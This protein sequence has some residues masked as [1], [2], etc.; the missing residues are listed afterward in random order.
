M[1]RQGELNDRGGSPWAVVLAGGGITVTV[2]CSPPVRRRAP[3]AVRPS[4]GA[5]NAPASDAGPSWVGRSSRADRSGGSREPWTISGGG[6]SERPAPHLLKQPT[7]RGTAAAILFAAQWIEARDPWA[8]VVFCPS[9]HFIPEEIEFM[10]RVTEVAR[11]V[12]RQRDWMVLLGAEPTEP[13]TEYRSDRARGI[14]GRGRGR[15]HLPH[16]AVPGEAFERSRG[17]IV[18]EGVSVEHVCLC[19]PGFRGARRGADACRAWPTGWP[20]SRRSGVPPMKH[21]RSARRTLSRRRPTSRGPFWRRAHSLL[22]S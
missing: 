16:P 18:H 17:T 3:Q 22:P 10:E 11:F 8:T 21:G 1:A 4:A 14:R 20:A 5:T 19:R 9:D 6:I 15:P 2:T 7:D 12:E 13:E